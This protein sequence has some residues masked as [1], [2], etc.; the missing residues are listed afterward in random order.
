MSGYFVA[1]DLLRE[2]IKRHGG[3]LWEIA[4]DADISPQ[5][6]NN[7]LKNGRAHIGTVAKLAKVFG[8]DKKTLITG[9]IPE[10][11][12][13]GR[14]AAIDADKLSNAIFESAGTAYQ[15]SQKIDVH[16]MSIR[17]LLERGRCRLSTLKKICA[18]LE[19]YKPSDFIK[20][21]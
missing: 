18:G 4:A 12:R 3:K 14:E 6:L 7:V 15:L 10:K 17:K 19:G 20:E 9:K 1:A 5:T 2:L 11:A 21:G 13:D 8:V 16:Y